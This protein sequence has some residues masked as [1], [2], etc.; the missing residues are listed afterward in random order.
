MLLLDKLLT[1]HPAH[2]TCKRPQMGTWHFCKDNKVLPFT[3]MTNRQWRRKG[4]H[5]DSSKQPPAYLRSLSKPDCMT[6][7]TNANS[8][9]CLKLA[10]SLVPNPWQ[11]AHR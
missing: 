8:D 9:T 10:V 5:S 1:L 4:D 2:V 11:C 6:P 7:L 3:R